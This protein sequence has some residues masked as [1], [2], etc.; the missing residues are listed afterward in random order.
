L[1]AQILQLS[2]PSA[3]SLVVLDY[4]IQTRDSL[5]ATTRKGIANAVRVMSDLS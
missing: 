4:C 3:A 1:S 5:L 2:D